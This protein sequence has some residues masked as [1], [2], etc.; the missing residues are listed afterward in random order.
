MGEKRVGKQCCSSLLR[1]AE[2]NK[3]NSSG[4]YSDMILAY[5]RQ[6]RN[7][8]KAHFTGCFG[9][10]KAEPQGVQQVG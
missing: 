6:F 4:G 1:M 3:C 8:L 2:L 9:Y 5:Y 7:F 10:F